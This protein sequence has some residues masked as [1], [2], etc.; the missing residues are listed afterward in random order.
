MSV[1]R[2]APLAMLPLLPLVQAQV[3][4]RLGDF[5]AQEEI[6]YVWSGEKLRRLV[7]GFEDFLADVYWLRTVQYFGGQRVFSREK[8]FE[9]L[10]PLVNVTTAL[11]PRLEIAY[12]SGAI[13]LSE[14]WPV[15]AGRPAAGVALLARGAEANP[16]AWRLRQQEGYFTFLFLK[17]AR[18]GADIL[19]EASKIPG[20][21]FWLKSLAGDLLLK[22]GERQV[23]RQV[24]RRLLDQSEEGVL[25]ENARAR[26]QILD[27]LDTADAVA[28]QVREFERRHGRR[29][30]SLNEL[31]AA[32][33]LP[34][35]P[36]D[37]TGVPFEYDPSMGKVR[38]STQSSLWRP[39]EGSGS[40]HEFTK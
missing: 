21:P 7:P 24:W 32:G 28:Q 15:G 9:L 3:D 20:A 29:P 22:G 33:L 16:Q 23:A 10:E 19:L 6:L 35:P 34:G 1:W 38:V 18:K 27:A 5:R 8:R 2:L 40:S 31:Q 36:V 39:E 12:R 13:F 17:D 30:T 25:R 11:D 26:L 37:P 4:R 14:S